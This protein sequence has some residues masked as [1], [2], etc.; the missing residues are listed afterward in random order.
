MYIAC[1]DHVPIMCVS[2]FGMYEHVWLFMSTKS[3]ETV[4][5]VFQFALWNVLCTYNISEWKVGWGS[6]MLVFLMLH[7]KRHLHLTG[8][9]TCAHGIENH[10]AG[11]WILWKCWSPPQHESCSWL[12]LRGGQLRPPCVLCIGIGHFMRR[13][14]LSRPYM[15]KYMQPI[16]AQIHAPKH[17]IIKSIHANLKHY[18]LHVWLHV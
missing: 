9:R 16:H 10:R 5:P 12:N 8:L 15:L 17:A 4:C 14:T 6:C 7:P 11:L 1:K 13:A 3:S 18:K 2:C